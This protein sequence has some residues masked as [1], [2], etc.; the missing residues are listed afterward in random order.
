MQ[1]LHDVMSVGFKSVVEP[2]A[3]YLFP[4]Y[5]VKI[6]RLTRPVHKATGG[7]CNLPIAANH[8]C[9]DNLCNDAVVGEYVSSTGV[10]SGGY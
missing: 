1:R 10:K 3:L 7:P 5:H 6:V 4:E 9:E 8:W 2:R